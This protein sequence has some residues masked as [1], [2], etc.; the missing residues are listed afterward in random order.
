MSN[1]TRIITVIFALFWVL[2]VFTDYWQKHPVYYLSFQLFE[3]WGLAIFLTTMGAGVVWLASKFG[4]QKKYQGLFNGLSVFALFLLIS[5][6]SVGFVY[7]KTTN[8]ASFDLPKA[9]RVLGLIGGVSLATYSITLVCFVLGNLIND[10]LKVRLKKGDSIVTDLASGIMGLVLVLFLL[11]AVSLLHSFIIFPLMAVILLAGRKKALGFLKT[12]LLQPL[13]ANK[14]LNALGLACFFGLVVLLSL[15][16]TA[17]NVPMPA[18]FDTLTLYS[19]LPSLIGQHHALVA[20]F[21]PYNWSVFMS[22]GQILFSSTPVILALSYLGGALA[23]YAMYVLGRNWLNLDVNY[24]LVALL[25]FALIPVFSGQMSAEL[26]VDLGLLFIYLS[27]VLLLLN[28]FSKEPKDAEDKSAVKGWMQSPEILLMGLLS[29]FSLGIKLTTLYFA[30]AV[31]SALWYH[32]TAKRGMFAV[33]LICLFLVFLLRIDE[34]GG[35]RQYHLGVDTLKWGVLLASLFLF[36]GVYLD[37]RKAL[38]RSIRITAFYGI[39]FL[40]PFLPWMVKN[41]VD[42]KSLSPATL[43]SGREASPAINLQIIEQN[44]QNSGH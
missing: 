34:T 44:W 20:G 42:T 35:L 39:F 15:N 10:A 7:G 38:W 32:R 37:N 22:L 12:T 43:M 33:F 31:V 1:I 26:K 5:V 6:V 14:S 36:A 23:L 21:Q 13:A 30:F 41:Y 27:V 11:G 40:L 16:F 19:N 17:L 29:G 24:T 3:Y 2:F 25:A 4:K 9:A 28:Y 18:G 8:N